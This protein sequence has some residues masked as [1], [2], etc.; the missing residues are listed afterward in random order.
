MEAPHD[1]PLASL[2]D[3]LADAA[4]A[5]AGATAAGVALEMGV[6][7]CVK[8]LRNPRPAEPDE[9]LGDA[10]QD[11]ELLQ[12]IRRR[13]ARQT[14]AALRAEAA[15]AAHG[16]E[17]ARLTAYRT[18]RSLVELALQVLQR[19]ASVL[20]RA[21]SPMLPD[22]ELAWRLVGASLEAELASCEADLQVLPVD[23]LVG[24]AESLQA[25]A[26]YGRELQARA[27]S[28]LAWRLR[29]C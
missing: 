1:T 20:V 3:G 4:L 28:E 23:W 17:A 10:G 8:A 13:I 9:V 6:A 22:L 19:F 12:A 5:P 7:L 2:L 21:G 16:T 26:R 18:R 27:L 25:Q 11:I 29:R 15:W 24:E 14:R